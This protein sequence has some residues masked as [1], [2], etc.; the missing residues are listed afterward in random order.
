M[1]R[2]L[3]VQLYPVQKEQKLHLNKKKNPQPIRTFGEILCI[4]WA[5]YCRS[6]NMIKYFS[7]MISER[8]IILHKP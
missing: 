6:K 4:Q 8:E 5:L 1:I 7:F 2:L 3:K